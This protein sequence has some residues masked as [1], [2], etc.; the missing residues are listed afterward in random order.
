MKRSFAAPFLPMS[1]IAGAR[2]RPDVRTVSCHDA[3]SLVEASGA[4]VPGTDPY[5]YERDVSSI[6][7]SSYPQATRP[8]WIGT[9]DRARRFI[10][11]TCSDGTQRFSR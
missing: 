9:A 8:A 2:T 5:S 4:L 6:R 1:S 11:N 10:G 7:Y 3:S